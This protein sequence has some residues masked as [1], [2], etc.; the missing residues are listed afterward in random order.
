MCVMENDSAKTSLKILVVDDEV[1]IRKTLSIGLEADGHVVTSVSN[2]ADAQAE[3]AKRSFDLAFVDLRL[4]TADG[5]E[6]IPALLG[7]SPW[8][9]IVVITAHGSIDSA[10]KA[11]KRGAS[12]Y[13]TKPFSPAQVALVTERVAKLRALEQ[14]V[15][16]L[17]GTSEESDS[18]IILES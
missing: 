15:A 11:M 17:Q 3:N 18:G 7:A 1:N 10:V 5:M 8:L 14:Q 16:T 6:L 12:D 4:G 13:L 9:R 2:A